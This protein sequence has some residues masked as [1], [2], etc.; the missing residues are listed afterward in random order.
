MQE[1]RTPGQFARIPKRPACERYKNTRIACWKIP[2]AT[3]GL[4][5]YPI[6]E[7]TIPLFLPEPLFLLSSASKG[8]TEGSRRRS[9]ADESVQETNP[10]DE[11]SPGNSIPGNPTEGKRQSRDTD[12]SLTIEY[13]DGDPYFFL[14]FNCQ[15]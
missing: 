15:K 12:D 1:W 5:V 9:P 13:A 8:R 3:Q 7:D 14:Y 2:I 4:Q 6:S 10:A 11:N